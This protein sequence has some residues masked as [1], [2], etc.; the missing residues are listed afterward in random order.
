M[1]V[2]DIKKTDEFFRLLYDVKGRFIPHRITPEEAKYK[3]CKVKKVYVGKN[4]IPL[5]TTHD[6]RTIRYPDPLIKANDTI[7][8]NLE[9]SKIEE[10]IKFD[11]GSLAMI[12][13]GKN[14]GRIG[15]IEST[16]RHEGSFHIVHLKDANGHTFATR[17]DNVFIIGKNA[18]T[19]LVSLPRG[20]GLR[21]SIIEEKERRSAKK[22]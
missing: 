7:K 12:T 11:S 22:K 5:L 15:L 3:L 6:G 17:M 20:K 16:E 9:T 4:S 14:L 21:L 8:F 1:D 10:F 13:G 2:I 18:T 19:P